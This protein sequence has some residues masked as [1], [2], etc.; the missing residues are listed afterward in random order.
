MTGPLETIRAVFD[1]LSEGVIEALA[2][3]LDG[4]RVSVS[5]SRAALRRFIPDDAIAATTVALRELSA[6]GMTSAQAALVLRLLAGERREQ[7]RLAERLELV[8]SGPEVRGLRSRDTAVVV[9]DLCRVATASILIANFAFDRPRPGD[10][11]KIARARELWQPLADRMEE[12]PRLDV[13]MIVHI[14]R[15]G[16]AAGD[17]DP[18]SV[19]EFLGHFRDRLW[20]GRRE[21]MIYYDPRALRR[22]P[23][24]R[25]NQHAKCMIVDRRE[26]FLTSANFSQAGQQR[27]IEAGLL[28]DDEG[29]ARQ[30]TG[31]FEA[32]IDAGALRRAAT[33]G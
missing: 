7:R 9:R 3:A 31:N 2:A 23:T 30:L 29:L 22:A 17:D 20:P 16:D 4:G 13:R 8:W 33:R 18:R 1:G 5:P 25:A 6:A 19:D 14:D 12:L 21:P 28:V 27:N 10:A 24:E 32:L 26:V 15:L 11:E